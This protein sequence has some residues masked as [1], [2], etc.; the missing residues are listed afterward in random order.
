MK[1]QG[2]CFYLQLITKLCE[3]ENLT[4]KS[5]SLPQLYFEDFEDDQNDSWPNCH[6]VT[7]TASAPHRN[8][9]GWWRQQI[10]ILYGLMMYKLIFSLNK[11]NIVLICIY[12]ICYAQLVYTANWS[13]TGMLRK[14]AKQTTPHPAP[15]INTVDTFTSTTD[16]I[17]P[18]FNILELSV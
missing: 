17:L 8:I 13:I 5:K 16:G 14:M 2:W 18:H 11:V 1:M 15:G 7:Y 12:F 3:I 9:Q 4:V 6:N 10:W